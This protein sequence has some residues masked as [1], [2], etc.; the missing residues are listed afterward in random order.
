MLLDE[1]SKHYVVSHSGV[2]LV[3]QAMDKN[4]SLP[5]VVISVCEAL[6]TLAAEGDLMKVAAKPGKFASFVSERGAVRHIAHALEMHG[7]YSVFDTARRTLRLLPDSS[8][9]FRIS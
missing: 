9:S 5:G 3:L 4:I 8:I 2:D 7:S 6:E 1:Q